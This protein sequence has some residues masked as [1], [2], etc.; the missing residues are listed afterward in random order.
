MKSL[1]QLLADHPL[2]ERLD[3][4]TRAT[5]AECATNRHLADHEYLF[6]T[7]EPARH[8]YLVRRGRVAFELAGSA[9]RR[10]DIESVEAGD[11]AGTSWLV[12]PYRWHLDARAVGPTDVIALDAACLRAKCEADPRAG[13]ELLLRLIAAM[14]E[15]LR[16]VRVQLL[17][18]Y[19]V[20][21]GR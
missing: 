13:Y 3:S 7:G 8:C 16:S 4:T 2:F 9:G 1:E 11:V 18:V 14:H 10:I 20:P 19:G 12:P 15:R 21:D 6:R 17:D 5:L